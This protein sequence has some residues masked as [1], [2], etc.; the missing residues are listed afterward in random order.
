MNRMRTQKNKFVSG[1][2][3]ALILMPAL[4]AAQFSIIESGYAFENP[5]FL[6]SVGIL[7]YDSGRHRLAISD[8][9]RDAILVFD[10]SDMAY[11]TLERDIG[12]ENHTG[13]A[14]DKAGNLYIAQR[15]SRILL[16]VNP[17]LTIYDS[18]LLDTGF[19]DE[20]TPSRLA[21]DNSGNLFVIDQ[22]HKIVGQFDSSGKF[23]RKITDKLRRPDGIYLGFSNV[24]YIADKGIDPLLQYS[25]AGKYIGNLSRPEDPAKQSNYSASG[26]AVDQRGWLYT[27]DITHNKLISFDPTGVIRS[28]WAPDSPFFP[29]DIVID[30]YD[31]IYISE[32]G[33]GRILVAGAK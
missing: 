11:Q 15:E 1:V 24:L 8:A 21:I 29:R 10:L 6:A 26:L 3:A 4:A 27:L 18:L 14:F 23:I 32:S 28:E 33:S 16:R 31:N 7:A 2:F 12:F 9:G 17:E 13:L 22:K 30:K 19:V 5:G 20:F 25:L